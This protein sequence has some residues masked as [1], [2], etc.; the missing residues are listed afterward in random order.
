MELADDIAYGVHDIEDIVARRLAERALV[1]AAVAKAFAAIGGSLLIKVRVSCEK[2]A[3]A[4]RIAGAIQCLPSWP[5]SLSRCPMRCNSSYSPLLAGL[6]ATMK[7][8]R[9]SY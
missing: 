2:A 8:S 7:I 1:Q 5:S 4:G 3:D 6:I 9:N